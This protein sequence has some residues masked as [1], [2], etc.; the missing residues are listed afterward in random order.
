MQYL[1]YYK[2]YLAG[3]NSSVLFPLFHASRLKKCFTRQN[4]TWNIVKFW[5]FLHLVEIRLYFLYY[6]N[7]MHAFNIRLNQT[8][9]RLSELPVALFNGKE[10]KKS[11]VVLL[12][13]IF[14]RM[15]YILFYLLRSAKSPLSMHHLIFVL[16]KCYDLVRWI[17]Y[18]Y[19][20]KIFLLH[21][22]FPI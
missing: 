11:I 22:I 5:K 3:N 20:K 12:K 6:F 10:E 17:K 1:S 7:I 14:W 21:S 18:I 15:S 8:Y 4:I 16:L 19:F 9:N 2:F 13:N